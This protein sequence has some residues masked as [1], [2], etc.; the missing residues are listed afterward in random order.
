MKG[1]AAK[2]TR[3]TLRSLAILA[4]IGAVVFGLPALL[5]DTAGVIAAGA[6]LVAALWLLE[7]RRVK[8]MAG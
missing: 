7:Y 6:V 3:E 8:R 2:A 4:V 5:G 1:P